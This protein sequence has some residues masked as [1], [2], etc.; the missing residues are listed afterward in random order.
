MK[1]IIKI[2]SYDK[3]ELMKDVD[4]S[5]FDRLDVVKPDEIDT[6]IY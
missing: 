6:M 1:E 5:F 2:G 4:L 3:L